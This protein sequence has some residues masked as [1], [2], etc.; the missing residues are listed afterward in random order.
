MGAVERRR[1]V[2]AYAPG[3]PTLAFAIGLRRD[4]RAFSW[5]PDEGRALPGSDRTVG[6]A[7]GGAACP[8]RSGERAAGCGPAAV[9]AAA[10]TAGDLGLA[11]TRASAAQ[12]P[13]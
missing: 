6:S 13:L 8:G 1:E 10:T 5:R 3:G 12:R 7:G 4:A 11:W 9:A 2:L